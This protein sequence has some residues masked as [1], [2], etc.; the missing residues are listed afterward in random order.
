MQISYS[1][2]RC[3][4]LIL[5]NVKFQAYRIYFYATRRRIPGRQLALESRIPVCPLDAQPFF[6]F[7]FFLFLFQSRKVRNEGGGTMT[8]GCRLEEPLRGTPHRRQAHY[9]SLPYDRCRSFGLGV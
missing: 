6:F 5:R 8:D 9:N 2:G 7:L 3:K 1:V 4:F